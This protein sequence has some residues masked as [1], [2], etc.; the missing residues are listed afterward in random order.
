MRRALLLPAVFAAALAAGEPELPSSLGVDDEY[1]AAE[2]AI[3]DI[4]RDAGAFLI[5]HAG[6][7]I[8]EAYDTAAAELLRQSRAVLAD[9]NVQPLE[10]WYAASW[11]Y[12]D[13]RRAAWLAES[14]FETYP[15]SRFAGALLHQALLCRARL[16]D[17]RDV[18]DHL[19]RLW[20]YIEDYP[21]LGVSMLAA[22]EA[23]EKR[24]AFTARIDLDAAD[25]RDVVDISGSYQVE[26]SNRIFAFLTR[27]GDR[28]DVAPRA[29]LGLARARLLTAKIEDAYTARRGYE[30]FLYTYPD[31]PLAFTALLELALSHLMTYR[32]EHYDVGALQ[33]A[34]AI[35]E[36]AEIQARGDTERVA[37]VDAYRRRIRGWL[38]DR[39]LRAARWYV[40]RGSIAWLRE[41]T[42]PPG[43]TDWAAGAR[44][45]FAQVIA[46]DPGTAQARAA[47][48][49]RA[50]LP[51]AAP[52]TPALG[53]P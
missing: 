13:A 1:E 32:G 11:L 29:L 45:Y 36:Q 39:D 35:I 23:S 15:H 51:P 9:G 8:T 38:Q 3:E 21:E 26:E 12:D 37:Q 27:H 22:L 6:F 14:G 30:D 2:K 18:R 42:M 41:I 31:H 47:E 19:A 53:A 5:E 33:Q 44:Y 25:P 7:T 49:E 16:G 43:L 34:Q 4:R 24:Q 17:L 40:E 48:R 52:A 50:A 46:R 20:F 28:D 10:A